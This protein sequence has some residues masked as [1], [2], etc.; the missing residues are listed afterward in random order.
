MRNSKRKNIRIKPIWLT[1]K[2][3][4]NISNYSQKQ[5]RRWISN[6]TLKYKRPGRKYLINERWLHSMI[7]FG[8]CG[9]LNSKEKEELAELLK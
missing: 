9:R 6:G 1:I 4:S 7:L 5:I 8:K 2:E 3:C